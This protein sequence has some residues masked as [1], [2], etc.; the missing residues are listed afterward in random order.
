[1]NIAPP[2]F[3]VGYMAS[4]KT[5]FGRALARRLNREFIDLDFYIEQRFRKSVR[6]LFAERGEEGFRLLE[7]EMLHEVGE[8]ENIVVACGGGTPCFFDNMQYMNSRGL[9][10]MMDAGIDCIVRRVS[11]AKDKRPLLAG[12][13]ESELREYIN[14]HLAMRQEFYNQAA[15]RFCGENLENSR[16]IDSS[17]DKFMEDYSEMLFDMNLKS[18]TPNT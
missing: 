18:V 12:K 10:V 3:I 4:G 11:L 14:N 8:F 13:N 7:T 1:M 16:E 6:V 17:I 9:S 5:T 15:I 2:I